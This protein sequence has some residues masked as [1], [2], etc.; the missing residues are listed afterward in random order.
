MFAFDREEAELGSSCNV[1]L[2]QAEY[3]WYLSI[4]YVTLSNKTKNLDRPYLDTDARKLFYFKVSWKH[5]KNL[6]LS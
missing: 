4:I 5:V 2:N 3:Y 6:L 1:R